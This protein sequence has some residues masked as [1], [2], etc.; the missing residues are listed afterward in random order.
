MGVCHLA[1]SPEGSVV[2]LKTV[3]MWKMGKKEKTRAEGEAKLLKSVRHPNIV[4]YVHSWVTRSEDLMI[5][6]EYVANG[7]LCSH[8]EKTKSK[9]LWAESK[10][11]DW[12]IQIALAVHYTGKKHIL[13]RDLKTQNILVSEDNVMKVAD[14]GISR[15]LVNTWEQ[16]NTFVGTPYYLAPELVMQQAYNIQVDA[17]AIGVVLCEMLTLTHPFTGHDMKSLASNIVRGVYKKPSATQ[18]SP[19]IRNIVTQLLTKDP[20]KRMTVSQSL[21]TK[22]VQDRLKTWLTKEGTVPRS[23]LL[24]LINEGGL[25]GVVPAALLKIDSTLPPA[26]PPSPSQRNDKRKEEMQRIMDDAQRQREEDKERIRREFQDIHTSPKGLRALPP[27]VPSSSP[28]PSP[29]NRGRRPSREAQFP[30]AAGAAPSPGPSP[31]NRE[32]RA[33]SR[34]PSSGVRPVNSRFPAVAGAGGV[35]VGAGAGAGGAYPGHYPVAHPRDLLAEK[36]RILSLMEQQA[37]VNAAAN[38]RKPAAR[39]F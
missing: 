27:S 36:R 4:R 25:D 21:Q 33:S 22:I 16:A 23:Y 3:T 34:S 9:G 13:H 24:G 17:W 31:S 39:P 5:A 38:R 37:N 1:K 10:V 29:N 32:R 15:S 7:D 11:L 2:V 28:T 8:I 19:E 6:M 12:F 30:P 26:A 35:G 14:F 20:K 18:Y